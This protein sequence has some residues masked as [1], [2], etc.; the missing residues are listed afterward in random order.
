MNQVQMFDKD[1]YY[2]IRANS[3]GVFMGKIDFVD[4]TT[5]G[6]KGL[7]RLYYWSGALDCT[8]LASNGVRNPNN[9]KFSVTLSENDLSIITNLIEF[10]LM[11]EKAIISINNVPVWKA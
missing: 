2:I 1:K 4:G 8:E 10:H 7:R 5:I 3:A 9:C 11:T 6:V